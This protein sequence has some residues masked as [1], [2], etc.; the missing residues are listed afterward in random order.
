M[1]AETTQLKILST[2]LEKSVVFLLRTNEY[3]SDCP[4]AKN[5]SVKFWQTYSAAAFMSFIALRSFGF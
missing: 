1:K 3:S 4:Y 5:I 2:L